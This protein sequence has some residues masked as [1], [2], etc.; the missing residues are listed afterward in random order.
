M[1]KC[2]H[3]NNLISS[4]R[5]HIRVEVVGIESHW[6]KQA[7]FD[8]WNLLNMVFTTEPAQL[9][10]PLGDK[11]WRDKHEEYRILKPPRVGHE[12]AST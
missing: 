12:T 2:A 9:E 10:L 8:E 3:C 5:S 4:N 7:C 6:C 11:P 1:Y